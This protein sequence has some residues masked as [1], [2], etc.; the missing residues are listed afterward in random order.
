MI[1]RDSTL[2]GLP[3]SREV[4]FNLCEGRGSEQ[5][6]TS[7]TARWRQDLEVYLLLEQLPLILIFN[8]CQ[9]L[10]SILPTDWDLK[11]IFQVV[12]FA[13]LGLWPVRSK[14]VNTCQHA[15]W[16]SN[17]CC[18][19][20]LCSLVS[21]W[22]L[23]HMTM[24]FCTGLVMWRKNRYSWVFIQFHPQW[25]EWEYSC[26]WSLCC[27]GWGEGERWENDMI[28]SSGNKLL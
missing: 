6:S 1:P 8:L 10:T 23:W 5:W 20:H 26:E 28:D 3:S 19:L 25:P 11:T 14:S 15:S 22:K 16:L 7:L 27:E 18:Y 9:L 2:P 13:D 4:S 12:T 17:L 21:Y 24:T